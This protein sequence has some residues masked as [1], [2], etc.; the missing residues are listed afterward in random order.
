M[1]SNK[2]HDFWSRLVAIGVDCGRLDGAPDAQ[3]PPT[4]AT[5]VETSPVPGVDEESFN[6][7]L[8]A[9]RQYLELR[10]SAAGKEAS[11]AL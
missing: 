11:Y 1:R 6:R 3:E 9:F 4:V 7:R 5:E 2:S 8:L 10:I